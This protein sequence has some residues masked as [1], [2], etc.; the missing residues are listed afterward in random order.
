MTD[1]PRPPAGCD[2]IEEDPRQCS[3]YYYEREYC[4]PCIVQIQRQTGDRSLDAGVALE[5]NA[6]AGRVLLG[7]THKA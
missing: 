4:L 3:M 7:L 5:L 6:N 1:K 2:H